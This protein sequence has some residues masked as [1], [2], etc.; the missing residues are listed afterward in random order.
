MSLAGMVFVATALF[1]C[2]IA[3]ILLRRNAL[4]LLMGVEL[5]LNAANLNLVAFSRW[6]GNLDGQVFAVFVILLAACEAAVALGIFLN[7]YHRFE[8]IEVDEVRTLRG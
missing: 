4:Y 7:L 3:T 8:T 2:G 1:V 6:L 5:I